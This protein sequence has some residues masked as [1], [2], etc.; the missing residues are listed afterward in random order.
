MRPNRTSFE[1]LVNQNKEQLMNDQQALEQIDK[2]I[3]EKRTKTTDKSKF[4][5]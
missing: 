2:Q 1:E 5:N 3:D 4:V